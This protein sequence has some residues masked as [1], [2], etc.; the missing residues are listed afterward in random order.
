MQNIC[1][2]LQYFLVNNIKTHG[3]P[4]KQ[5]RLRKTTIANNVQSILL[6]F[7]Q[8]LLQPTA[9]TINKYV[10][11]YAKPMQNL[12]KSYAILMFLIANI[13]I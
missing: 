4:T 1:K 10:S 13:I 6:I 9:R 12:C 2:Q 8:K 3:Q 11:F 5:L 7:L